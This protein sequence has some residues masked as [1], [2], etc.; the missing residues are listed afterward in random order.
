MKLVSGCVYHWLLSH[1]YTRA[2]LPKIARTSLTLGFVIP[3]K[4]TVRTGA[5]V[6]LPDLVSVICVL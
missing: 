1:T 4:F 2:L 5:G 6:V 3:H